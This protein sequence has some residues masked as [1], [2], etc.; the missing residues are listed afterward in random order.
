MQLPVLGR[1]RVH[2]YIHSEGMAGLYHSP[3]LAEAEMQLNGKVLWEEQRRGG[4]EQ[5]QLGSG[6]GGFEALAELAIPVSLQ[7]TRRKLEDALQRLECLYEKL[8]EQAVSRC[9]H[10]LWF[11]Q[12]PDP[13]F[14]LGCGPWSLSQRNQHICS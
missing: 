3:G 6:R 8:R 7:K 13:T 12:V 2:V 4:T 1:E 14:A 10:S 11:S 5:E 9:R